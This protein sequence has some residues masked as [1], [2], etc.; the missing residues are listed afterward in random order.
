MPWPASKEEPHARFAGEVTG[1]PLEP[2]GECGET[3]GGRGRGGEGE[4][5]GGRG[6]EGEGETVGGRGRR[7]GGGGERERGEGV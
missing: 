7:W 3:V 6:G 2:A 5:V 4:T 1:Y